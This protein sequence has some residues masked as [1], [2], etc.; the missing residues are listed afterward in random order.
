MSDD[1]RMVMDQDENL[2]AETG[3]TG[4]KKASREGGLGD[5][6]PL[7][8]WWWLKVRQKEGSSSITATKDGTEEMLVCVVG[9]G[10][11]YARV[12][13]PSG[14][15]WRLHLE[16]LFPDVCRPCPNYRDVI[17]GHIDESRREIS[18][19]MGKVQE[20]TAQIGLRQ[21]GASLDEAQTA[22]A[23][24]S[25]TD[26]AKAYEKALVKAKDETLPALFN[27][28]EGA[29]NELKMWMK[30]EL[31]PVHAMANK[32]KSVIKEVEDRIFNVE[33]YAGISEEAILVRDGEPAPAT[34]KLRVF[35]NLLYM[36]EECLLDYRGGGL[37]FSKEKDFDRWLAKKANADRIL[38]FP[39]CLVAMQVRRYTKDRSED[40]RYQ[41]L[42][43]AHIKFEHEQF[44]KKTY[45]FVRNGDRIFRINSQMDF[46]RLIFPSRGEFSAEPLMFKP[47]SWSSDEI[48]FITVRDYEARVK[49]EE[50]REEKHRAWMRENP[51][52]PW[53][54]KTRREKWLAWKEERT[55]ARQKRY[56]ERMEAR[57]KTHTVVH[58]IKPS[59][60]E[61][62]TVDYVEAVTEEVEEPLYDSVFEEQ[63]PD[64]TNW[65]RREHEAFKC[66]GDFRY[67]WERE[68]PYHPSNVEDRESTDGWEPFDSRST[69]FDE[70]KACLDRKI[71]EWNRV[72]LVVQGL[73]D[74]SNLLDPHPPVRLWDPKGFEAA[75]DLIYDGEHAIHMGEPPDFE[76]YRRRTLETL[77]QGSVTIGQQAA[78][79]RK[80]REK[81]Q[82]RRNRD[83]RLDGDDAI[84]K[85][86]W[87]PKGE[88]GPGFVAEVALW[89]PNKR[90]AV[91]RFERYAERATVWKESKNRPGWGH[92]I[93]GK[94]KETLTVPA[95]DLFNVSAYRPGDYKQFFQDPRTRRDYMQWAP[96]LLTAEDWHAG[97]TNKEAEVDDEDL[98][99]EAWD[100][101][102]TDEDEDD[103]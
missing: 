68:S 98:P 60:G 3:A 103:E 14:H 65:R 43:G 48:T 56:E 31:L 58:T 66:H 88:K 73:Y 72:S 8:S 57:G 61:Y 37:D 93:R 11:N 40:A 21:E 19:L 47:G 29:S 20:V 100:E 92:K 81:E 95:D 5:Q 78:W 63:V 80:V 12:K 25:A 97:K 46:K 71:K 18:D 94:V 82:E 62:G 30:A 1:E 45:L 74:R 90:E 102:E 54:M 24:L 86:W 32:A 91:F 50:E 51:Y 26:D 49:K 83:D 6:V 76:A 17:R 39:R 41:G 16:D 96:L 70:A 15:S 35:Q 2:P 36:D 44:D 79:A 9:L 10:S 23:T 34:E 99:E 89:R 38:P 27:Q 42:L 84:V 75:V 77:G 52:W 69:G 87:L 64:K 101:D 28:I 67:H 85:S 13:T 59:K 33:I 7:G 22:L 55:A 4:R 53:R